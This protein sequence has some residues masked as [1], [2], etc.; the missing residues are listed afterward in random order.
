MC[1]WKCFHCKIIVSIFITN[2]LDRNFTIKFMHHATR[3]SYLRRLR[4]TRFALCPADNNLPHGVRFRNTA[5]NP[6]DAYLLTFQCNCKHLETHKQED[7]MLYS[8]TCTRYSYYVLQC[9]KNLII[10]QTYIKLKYQYLV[11]KYRTIL[12]RRYK[13]NKWRII[14]KSDRFTI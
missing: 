1:I 14:W 6:K 7:E 11:Q 13:S 12:R 8:K 5:C 2:N 10:F 3:Y 4:Y 9:S